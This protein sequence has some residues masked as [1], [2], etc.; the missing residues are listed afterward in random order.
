MSPTTPAPRMR[1][2]MVAPCGMNCNLCSWVQD[3][4]KPGCPGCRPRG[5]GCVHKKGLCTK[6]ARREIYFCYLCGD[7]PCPSLS[8][9]EARYTRTHHYSFI[10]N[11]R[12]IRSRGLPA[13]LRR[14]T[15]RYTCPSCGDLLTVHADKCPHC[16]ERHNRKDRR[17]PARRLVI[18]ALAVLAG[19][20]PARGQ[21]VKPSVPDKLQPV[22][23]TR[24]GLGGELG[25]RLDDLIF[26]NY[27]VLDMDGFFVAPFQARP[28]TDDYHY[29]GAGKVID[30]GSLLAAYAG[31]PRVAERTSGLIDGI[32]R[33]RD[34]DGYIG[35]FQPEP[36]G[37]QNHRNWAL[38]EQEYLLL[39]LTRHGLVQGDRK[40]LQAARRLGD[41]VIRT[42]GR[43]PKPEEVCTAGLPEAF[44]LLYRATGD[45]RYLKFAAEVRHGNAKAEVQCAS[46]LDWKQTF[47][48]AAAHVYVMLA[49]CYAQT[50][51]YRYLGRPALLDMSAYMRHELLRENGG[52]NVIGSASDGEW[53]SYTQNGAGM[54][55]ESCVTAYLL[56][57][58][59]S[60]M[61]L[62]GDLRYGDIMERTIYNALLGAQD[63]EGRKIRYF[64]PFTGPRAYFNQD[65]HC[66]PGN[67]RRIMAEL[68]QKVYYRS[69]DG[70]VVVN[71]F[72]TS[73]ATVDL[74]G[75]L[76]VTV[77]QETDY[78]SSGHVVLR[79]TPSKDA[80]FA[81]RLRIPRWCRDAAVM[82][83]GQEPTPLA[84][85]INPCEIR[86]AWSAGDT[87]TLEMPMPWR[88]IRGREL[89]EGKA[90]LARGPV[91]Y[92][93]GTAQNEEILK[94]YP[95]F[96]G[97]VIDPAGLGEPEPD[98]SVRPDGLK[99]TV[100]A[101]VEAPGA[102]SKGAPA[103]TVTFTEFVDPTGLVTFVH[104]LDLDR[105]G[106]DELTEDCFGD[107][108]SAD[109]A[110]RRPS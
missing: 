89:Q 38:H 100:K 73:R 17:P 96:R 5:R 39:G 80:A 101:R 45:G 26:K 70:A 66:C 64:T 25:R 37:R 97:L 104:L 98:R 13:F 99:V 31:D 9:I 7:F 14:E 28:F 12:F 51:L 54:I 53:F 35:A 82:I 2:E 110:K 34:T 107:S 15:K 3:P 48:S 83:N 109:A 16:G 95:D 67:F 78:P 21:S 24:S 36:G 84:R 106:D 55:G 86:R 58:L 40:S 42:F 46:L 1:R 62:E 57:W 27:M 105:A 11:L 71:L 49:R 103:L 72:T 75:G 32:L 18:L 52:L 41:Y 102:W 6:L 30:A 44:L 10:E 88:F 108:R 69:A 19:A 92:C 94:K 29:V 56:R 76:S 59:E 79:V 63:P 4:A 50:E 85:G 60:L 47:D 93:L 61:R 22:T 43:D 68:P 91:I 23:L 90:A 8:A 77:S 20:G 33:T 74:D 87:V 81:L 65:G